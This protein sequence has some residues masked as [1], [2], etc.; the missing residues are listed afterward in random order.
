MDVAPTLYRLFQVEN[1]GPLDGR[2]WLFESP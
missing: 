1:P 2:A